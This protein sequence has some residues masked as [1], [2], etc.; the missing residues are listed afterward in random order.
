MYDYKRKKIN[1]SR[2]I[3]D[4]Y[5]GVAQ[6]LGL[7]GFDTV[8]LDE[9]FLTFKRNT[10]ESRLCVPSKFRERVTQLRSVTSHRT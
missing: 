10:K 7:V 1:E 3:Y 4:Y 9:W 2:D 5:N 8:S 6:D